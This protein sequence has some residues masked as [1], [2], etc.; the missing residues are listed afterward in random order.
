MDNYTELASPRK[1]GW[2]HP[3]CDKLVIDSS[4]LL[5]AGQETRLKHDIGSCQ[6][7][8]PESGHR[9][10]WVTGKSTTCTWVLITVTGGR[11]EKEKERKAGGKVHHGSHKKPR[12][13]LTRPLHDLYPPPLPPPDLSP[14][15]LPSTLICWRWSWEPDTFA[16]SKG[17]DLGGGVLPRA[18][19]PHAS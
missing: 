16:P 6:N 9:P 18:H 3:C 15:Q 5:T 19:L 14:L 17:S 8:A 12:S 1:A 11:G 7:L 13:L 4:T 2:V 10:H